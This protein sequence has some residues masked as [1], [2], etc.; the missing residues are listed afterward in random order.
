MELHAIRTRPTPTGPGK[1]PPPA[2]QVERMLGTKPDML[3][4]LGDLSYADTYLP[5]GQET[6]GPKGLKC[7]APPALPAAA[8]TTPCLPFLPVVP[9]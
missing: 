1:T 3:I 7:V 8:C 9:C 4:N 5:D 2:P 6:K